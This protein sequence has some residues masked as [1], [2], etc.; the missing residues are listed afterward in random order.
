MK[1][2]KVFRFA[3]AALVLASAF[4]SS[5]CGPEKVKAVAG[6]IYAA[7]GGFEQEFVE[8]ARRGDISAADGARLSAWTRE[9]GSSARTLSI[10]AEGWKEKTDAQKRA[11]ILQFVSEVAEAQNRLDAQGA[12]VFKSEKAR[13]R[14]ADVQ[15]YLSRAVTAL[16]IVE[17]AL[18]ASK[19][20]PPQ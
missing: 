18:P 2:L 19:S 7:S 3:L 4:V 8:A 9:V 11:A 13:R 14:F 6:A 20:S 16:R 5:A 1:K 12:P 15:L 10:T 17:A